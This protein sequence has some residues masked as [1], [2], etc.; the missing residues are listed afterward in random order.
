M[1]EIRAAT[2]VV[3][4]GGEGWRELKIPGISVKL[5]RRNEQTGESSAL[6]LVTLPKPV[7]ILEA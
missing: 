3:R 6:F 7:E 4:G 1:A 2:T 5:L